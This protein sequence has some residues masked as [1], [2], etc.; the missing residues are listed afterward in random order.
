MRRY[1]KRLNRVLVMLLFSG[2][3]TLFSCGTK[4]KKAMITDSVDE[5]IKDKTLSILSLKK[6][7]SVKK[8]IREESNTTY[9]A[10]YQSLIKSANKALNEGPFSVT[11]KTQTPVSGDKHDYLSIGPYWWPDPAKPDG[12]PWIRR[13]GE[14]NPLTLGENLDLQRKA[15]M[16]RNTYRLAMANFLSE[17]KKYAEKAIELLSVWFLNPETKMNPNLNYAQG[18]PGITDGRGIGIIEFVGIKEILTAI[19]L[20]EINT[21]MDKKT[22]EGLR[23]WLKD[24]LHWLQTSKNG[25]DE[26]K[27]KNNHG[28]WYDVQI[29]SLLM[30]FDRQDE[31][32]TVLE[33]VKKTRI[34]TQIAKDGK[35]PLELARTRPLHYSAY[36]L[37]A[38]T[39][40]AYF[41]K[42]VN[43]DLW[44]YNP[45]NAGGIKDAYNFLL[46]YVKQEKKWESEDVGGADKGLEY[47]GRLFFMAGIMF[48]VSEYTSIQN[49][50][51]KKDDF[52]IISYSF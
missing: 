42:K 26:S 45:S 16:F 40:L 1:F 51:N 5:S 41:G 47:L 32:K 2:C 25:I 31:A 18:I 50:M 8:A 34:D 4:S 20:L 22:S 7:N 15:N 13:D 36:N 33:S 24:Y 44:N 27:W 52:E 21:A 43:V 29:V 23:S 10:S 12:M 49:N 35:L 6:L 30:F 14:V 11:N 19:E 17:D 37:E 9:K 28:T 39:Y 3:I 48:D 46:P 38:F